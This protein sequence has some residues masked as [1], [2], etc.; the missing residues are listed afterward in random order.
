[1]NKVSI[2]GRLTGDPD[3]RVSGDRTIAR[4]GVAIQRRFK[5][6]DGEYE[7]DFVNCVAFG[8]QGE[9]VE[10]YFSKGMKAEIV[11]RLQ[12]GKYQNKDGNT[13]NTLDIVVEEIEFAES[14]RSVGEN[15]VSTQTTRTSGKKT[16]KKEE[17]NEG[18]MDIPEDAEDEGL[19]F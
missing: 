4:F 3:I 19:P 15:S 9:F 14:K 13:V 7:A 1:M 5:N 2:S 17:L 11:G 10:K 8:A 6:K 16:V 18:F 12:S